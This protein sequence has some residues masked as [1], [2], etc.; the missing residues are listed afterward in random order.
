MLFHL[1]DERRINKKHFA[2]EADQSAFCFV[3]KTFGREDGGYGE[4]FLAL[5]P[6]IPQVVSQAPGIMTIWTIY[7][8]REDRA[9]VTPTLSAFPTVSRGT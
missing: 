5:A 2:G 7:H 4:F 6:V 3:Y 9:I 8:A 1:Q